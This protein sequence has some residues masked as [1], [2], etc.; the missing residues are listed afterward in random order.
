M[1]LAK[2]GDKNPL[3]GTH[4]SLEIRK[5]I[6]LAQTGK[7]H[8][9]EWKNNIG[10]ALKGHKVSID[11][12]DKISRAKTGK[13]LAPFSENARINMSIARK[14]IKFSK[15]HRRK[16][17]EV[18]MGKYCGKDHPNWQGGITTENNKIRTSTEYKLWRKA[19]FERDNYQCIWG[20]KEHG[21]KLHADHIKPFALFPE[22][23]LAIDNGRTLCK[24]CH[25]KV[26][27]RW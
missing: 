8:T 24:D 21:N 4:P 9:E 15:E 22:L 7:K 16:L 13:K 23:R 19:V 18:R 5:K 2:T 20:G 6:I 12:R 17:S 26:H 3:F 27:K 1:S 14:G 25:K 11:T 10:N